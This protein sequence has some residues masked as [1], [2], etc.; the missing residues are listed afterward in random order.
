MVLERLTIEEII[1]SIENQRLFEAVDDKYGFYIKVESYADRIAAAI[2]DG[3]QLRPDLKDNCLLTDEERLYEE[4]PFTALFIKD[5]PI[6]IKGLDSRFEYDLNRVFEDAIYETAWGKQVWKIPLNTE[7]IDL[8][9]EKYQRFY[10]M[11]DALIGKLSSI[12]ETPIMVYDIH[13]YNYKRWDRKVPELNV[14]TSM[15]DRTKWKKQID[16]YLIA[17]ERSF[18][19]FWVAENNTFYGKGGFLGYIQKNFN[20]ALVLA[21]EF[22][23]YYCD[24]LTGRFYWEQ[25]EDTRRRLNSCFIKHDTSF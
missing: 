16:N 6:V 10:R 14:G 18:P 15:L 24:E 19:N 20:N 23:K 5:Q 11:V 17:L 2:H 21:T 4:D 13:S 8:S 9:R 7:Q 12:H 1:D 22:S 25:L 3:H